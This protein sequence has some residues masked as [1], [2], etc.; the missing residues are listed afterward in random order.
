[1]SKGLKTIHLRMIVGGVILLLAALAWM[2]ETSFFAAR[3]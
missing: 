2:Y 3:A 1:M